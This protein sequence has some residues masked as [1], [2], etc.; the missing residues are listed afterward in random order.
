MREVAS[1][2]CAGGRGVLGCDSMR[3][4][5]WIVVAVLLGGGI[6]PAQERKAGGSAHGF[7]ALEARLAAVEIREALFPVAL[8][9]L[10][11][12][13]KERHPQA[14]LKM[15][16]LPPADAVQRRVTLSLRNI[17]LGEAIRYVCEQVGLQHRVEAHAVVIYHPQHLPPQM[18]TR[19]YQIV[20]GTFENYVR[21]SRQR[22]IGGDERLRAAPSPG[23]VR[24]IGQ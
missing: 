11:A 20:P 5:S 10:E 24:I 19:T 21:A 8:A 7:Y 13:L 23:Q 15:I 4:A 16:I 6:S 3:K 2:D 17:P 9:Q 1:D 12:A 18:V 22:V 14:Q